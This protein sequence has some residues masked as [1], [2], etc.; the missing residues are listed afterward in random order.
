MTGKMGTKKSIAQKGG[1]NTRASKK[2]S[3]ED[4]E[5]AIRYMVNREIGLLILDRVF[6]LLHEELNKK[7]KKA[8]A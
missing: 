8:K 7:D 4:T 3:P 6:E 1:A 5:L 2:L